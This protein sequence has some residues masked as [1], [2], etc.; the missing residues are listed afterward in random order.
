MYRLFS[1]PL[2]LHRGAERTLRTAVAPQLQLSQVLKGVAGLNGFTRW[3]RSVE[4]SRDLGPD[5]LAGGGVASAPPV[6][7]LGDQ[8]HA[9]A[10]LVGVGGMAQV[11]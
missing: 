2:A 4:G 7:E 5:D 3:S 9:A 10:A 1:Q 8:E 11:G 6:G